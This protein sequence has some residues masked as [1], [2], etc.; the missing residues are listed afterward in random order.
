MAFE[1]RKTAFICFLNE[2]KCVGKHN[3]K[4]VKI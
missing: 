4:T 2:F 3:N 1:T